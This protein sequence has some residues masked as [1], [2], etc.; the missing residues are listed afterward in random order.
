[1]DGTQMRGDYGT[2][3]MSEGGA[4]RAALGRWRDRCN[5][6]GDRPGWIPCPLEEAASDVAPGRRTPDAEPELPAVTHVPVG[7]ARYLN[8]LCGEVAHRD[9]HYLTFLHRLPCTMGGPGPVVA[10]HEP[11]RSHGS[12]DYDAVPLSERYHEIRHG[13]VLPQ[14]GEPTAEEIER[15]CLAAR[16]GCVLAYF[17]GP[18]SPGRKQ[19]RRAA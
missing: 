9:P 2:K 14:A 10:H 12:S 13:H 16:L 15:A 17:A 19:A 1:M 3:P 18:V 7:L 4:K 6:N 11:P 5:V 8:L